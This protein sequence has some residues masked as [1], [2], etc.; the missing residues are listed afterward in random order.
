[1]SGREREEE[2]SKRFGGI[3]KEAGYDYPSRA[4]NTNSQSPERTYGKRA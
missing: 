2:D 1:M 3:S 4:L